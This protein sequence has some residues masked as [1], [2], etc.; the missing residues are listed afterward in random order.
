M[1]TVEKSIHGYNLNVIKQ[2]DKRFSAN[3]KGELF[4]KLHFEASA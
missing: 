1:V 2:L 3:Q 4:M